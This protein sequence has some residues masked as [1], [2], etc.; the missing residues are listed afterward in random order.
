MIVRWGTAASVA[1]L[2]ALAPALADV[3]TERS[4]SI[5]IFP[6]VLSDSHGYQTGGFP[7]ETIIQIS[8][9]SNLLVFVH[10]FYVTSTP[11]N[12]PTQ[13]PSVFNPPQWQEVDFDIMLTKQQPTHWVVGPGRRVA[14][15]PQCNSD[16]HN[17]VNAGFDP[18]LIPPVSDPFVGHM[19]CLEVDSS[20]APLNGNHL[21]GEVTL[22]TPTAATSS[23]GLGFIP[24][25]EVSKYNAIGIL[26]LNTNENSNNGDLSLCL[27]GGV[28]PGCAAG[29]EYNGCPQTVI[30]DH[31]A[32]NATEPAVEVLGATASNVQTELTVV[33]CTQDFENQTP[34]SVVGLQFKVTNEFE[35][36]FSAS[37]TVTCWSNFRLN[38]VQRIFDVNFLGSRFAQ[39]RLSSAD[40][41]PG[42]VGVSEEFHR[43]D[44]SGAG[45]VSRVALN[46][47]GEGARSAGDVITVP[48]VTP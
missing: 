8:N 14:P 39:T 5:L 28:R 11:E 4:S 18:G 38:E 40:D 15:D 45:R 9:T 19:V 46:L 33:P 6:K 29:A 37:T 3:T 27:G 12:D 31:F 48:E 41:Q 47:H 44:T 24:K 1:V 43:D 17:C 7:I 21:K 32:E 22:V 10:C 34:G 26:G 30:V 16:V 42:F 25:G 20:G 35:E 2:F 36:Q 13:R 23:Q